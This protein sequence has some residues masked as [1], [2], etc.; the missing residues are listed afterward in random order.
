MEKQLCIKKGINL[1]IIE[2]SLK[3]CWA[4]KINEDK[5]YI[6]IKD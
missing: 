4:K 5:D 3:K 1:V 2:A 6:I